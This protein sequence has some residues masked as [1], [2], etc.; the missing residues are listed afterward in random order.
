LDDVGPFGGPSGHLTK[1]TVL[2][3]AFFGGERT[4]SAEFE[5]AGCLREHR[6]PRV[7]RADVEPFEPVGVNEAGHDPQFACGVRHRGAGCEHA[8]GGAGPLFAEGGELVEQVR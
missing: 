1:A 7:E 3:E 5:F 2:G 4:V 8:H 6:P